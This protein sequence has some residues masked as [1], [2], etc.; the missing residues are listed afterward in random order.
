MQHVKCVVVGDGAVGKTCLLMVYSRNSFDEKY[1]PTVFDNYT[2]N[3]K[4]NDIY[5]ELGLWDT[6]GQEDYDRL[7][8]LSY[9]QTDVFLACFSLVYRSSF[10][11]I[12]YKW[13]P[14]IRHHCP[15]TPIILVGTKLDV[16]RNKGPENSRHIEK[17]SLPIT[18]SEGQS[19][20]KRI[21]AVKYIECSAKSQEGLQSVFEEAA[22]H[23]KCVVVGDGNVGKTC[24]LMV[25]SSNT[26]NE[27]YIPTVYDNY[28]ATVMVNDIPVEMGLWD[29]A[30]QEDYVRIRP[31]SYPQTDVFL[32]CFS[33]VY[34]SSF[35]NI[36]HQWIPEVRHHCSRTPILLVGT[37][38]DIRQEPGNSSHIEKNTRPISFSE[39]QSLAKRI[40]AVRY[41]E[42][43]AKTQEGLQSVFEEAAKAVLFPSNHKPKRRSCILL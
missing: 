31:L 43:S 36:L 34:R 23:V 38:L 15:R 40:D 21:D 42:C 32:V 37:K 24:L 27:D 11:N 39:G 20:A 6:S 8:P 3:V 26:F 9:P 13:I 7:R 1:I 17:N 30:G 33:L 14:E 10:V 22:K 5:I 19:L 35:D 2:A 16:R 4:V 25:Y 29:T 18:V 12:V 41:L 28:K